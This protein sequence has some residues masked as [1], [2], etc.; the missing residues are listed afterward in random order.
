MSN[1]RK[2]PKN[3][4]HPKKRKSYINLLKPDSILYST[5]IKDG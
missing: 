3:T 2:K 1:L 4:S 5:P